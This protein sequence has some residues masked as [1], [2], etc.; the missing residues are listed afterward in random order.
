MD[1]A[2]LFVQA[3]ARMIRRAAALALAPLL[4]A[5]ALSKRALP[6]AWAPRTWAR[7]LV[8]PLALLLLG[9]RRPRP[10]RDEAGIAQGDPGAAASSFGA[11][12]RCAQC[13][14]GG[15]LLQSKA[16]DRV[17]GALNE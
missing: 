2:K 17:H 3:V 10:Q 14:W 8:A 15:W 7:R 1:E 16:R 4:G 6:W 13:G 9:H 5:L 12:A 11:A